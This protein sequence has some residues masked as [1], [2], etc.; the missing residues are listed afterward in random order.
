MRI[1]AFDFGRNVGVVVGD[2]G[3]IP[4]PQTWELPKHPGGMLSQFE[5]RLC[6]LIRDGASFDLPAFPTAIFYE[7]VFVTKQ[8]NSVKHCMTSFGMAASV[9]RNAYDYG[10]PD[11]RC[12]DA[13]S[14]RKK[15]CGRAKAN[16]DEIRWHVQNRGIETTNT[17]EDDA[18]LVW[19]AAS[20]FLIARRE[21][22]DAPCNPLKLT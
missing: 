20:H 9:H 4:E 5:G 2:V 11:P 13:R 16:E 14:M 19:L 17:H 8:K 12:F 10:L 3:S 15:Y 7:R 6:G 18:A 1:I 21:K 22:K